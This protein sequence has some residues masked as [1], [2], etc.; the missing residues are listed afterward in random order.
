MKVDELRMMHDFI[1]DFWKYI[2]ALPPAWPDRVDEANAICK[3]YGEHPAVIGIM[4]AYINYLEEE[5]AAG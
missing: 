3:K 2:K 1:G 5:A 4:L